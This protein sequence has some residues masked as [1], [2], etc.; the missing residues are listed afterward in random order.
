MHYSK[1]A[2]H[3]TNHHH[4]YGYRVRTLPYNAHRHYYKGHTYYC[5]NNVWYRPYNGHYVICRPPFGTLLAANIISDIVW[6]AVRLSYYD[7]FADRYVRTNAASLADRL[8]LVQSYADARIPYYYQDGVFYAPGPDGQYYVIVP[9]AGAL[10]ES[11]PDDYEIV[12][13]GG[14]E[15]YRVDNTIYMMTVS[16]GRPYFEVLGQMN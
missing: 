7:T 8:G 9:P 15:Y 4:Y 2:H 1:P 16:E 6:T 14:K 10:V 13:L 3:W 12:V 5:Y 11:L